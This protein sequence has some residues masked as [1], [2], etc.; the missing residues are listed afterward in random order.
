[1]FQKLLVFSALLLLFQC[2]SDNS[3]R[4]QAIANVQA[5][6]QQTTSTPPPPQPS[7]RT[8]LAPGQTPPTTTQRLDLTLGSAETGANETACLPV[9]ASGFSDLIGLQF[10]IRWNPEEL[11]YDRVENLEL[12]DLTPQSFGATYAEKGVVAMAWYHLTLQGVSLENNA[13]LFD[14]CFTPKVGAGQDIEVRFESRPTPYEVVNTREE[15]LE[16]KGVNGVIRV[17]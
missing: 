16:F 3:V 6:T 7:T 5:S 15:I 14:I 17:K 13:H 2:K 1:M 12:P 11:T 4:E 9:T 10:S 8:D